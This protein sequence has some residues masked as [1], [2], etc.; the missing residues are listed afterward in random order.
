VVTATPSS[1]LYYNGEYGNVTFTAVDN[2][3]GKPVSG[4]HISVSPVPSFLNITSFSGVTDASGQFRFEFQVFPSNSFI[5]TAYYSGLVNI[6]ATVVSPV[7]GI[8]AGVGYTLVNDMPEPVAYTVSG[9]S[10]FQS[11]SGYKYYNITVY[12]PLTK[13][14]ISGYSYI[15]QSLRAAINMKPTTSVQFE[16]N[17]S[18]YNAACK[19]TSMSIPVNT[20]YN[21]SMMNSISGVTGSNGLISVMIEANSTFNYS[22]NGNSFESYIF[23]GDYALAAS[24]SGV[25]PYIPLGEL[26]SSSNPNGF[27][28]GEPFEIP[29]LVQKV[30]NNYTISISKKTVNQTTT[31]L[32]FTVTNGTKAVAGYNLNV[33]SQNSLGANR[34]YFLRS[35]NSTINPNYYL[36][37]S[38]GPETGSHFEPEAKLVTDSNGMAYAN[39]SSLFYTYNSTTG[40]ISPMSISSGIITPFDEFEI[41]VAGD[42]QPSMASSEVLANSTAP[43]SITFVESGLASG[44]IWSMKVGT[45]AESSATNKIVFSVVNGTYSYSTGSV[46]YYKITENSAGTVT[47]NG[48][49]ETINVAYLYIAHNVSFIETG[50]T[51]GTTW[52]VTLNIVTISSNS[53][54][55]TLVELNGTYSYAVGNVSGY[56]I[57]SNGTGSVNVT[58]K[59]VTVD[60]SF[61]PKVTVSYTDYYIIGGVIAA[62]VIIGG[63]AYALSRGK[64]NKAKTPPQ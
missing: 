59:N 11:G 5:N 37:E 35:S 54:T 4:A 39:F 49:S 48:S 51:S 29:M 18:T 28:A 1:T 52:N 41:S 50:L 14:K 19:F 7:S 6:S 57:S 22:L 53:T 27:G 20:T 45:L 43:Y 60:V 46:V 12:N 31:E 2:A 64:K 63:V 9:P 16:T 47:I 32:I 33:T 24:M 3:T 38:C 10:V 36:V 8:S 55:I 34:G 26:T 58:G 42:G 40:F 61:T 23:M 15:V 21:S 62:I 25:D 13:A 44:T 56:T 30:S 17:V